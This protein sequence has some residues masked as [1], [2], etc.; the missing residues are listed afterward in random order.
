M[1]VGNLLLAV[2][3]SAGPASVHLGRRDLLQ[4]I[5]EVMR[6]PDAALVATVLQVLK[7]LTTSPTLLQP[8]QVW[9]CSQICVAQ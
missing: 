8:M 3:Q 1:Q 9:L 4:A 5:F 7:C 2:A 6:W